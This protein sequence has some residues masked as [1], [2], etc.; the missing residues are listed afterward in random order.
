MADKNRRFAVHGFHQAN[1]ITDKV[2]HIVRADIW[3]AIGLAIAALIGGD[4][5]ITGRG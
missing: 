3:R 4:H 5:P 1:D 2:R